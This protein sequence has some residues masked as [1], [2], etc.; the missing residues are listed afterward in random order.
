MLILIYGT[1]ILNLENQLFLASI[2]F[3]AF[4]FWSPQ[5]S[6]E[7][8]GFTLLVNFYFRFSLNSIL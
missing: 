8:M 6:P 3:C 7:K 4:I 5:N 2:G 1:R